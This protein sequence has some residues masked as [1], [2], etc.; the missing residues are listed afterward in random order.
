MIDE[1]ASNQLKENKVGYNKQS[2]N[3][4]RGRRAINLEN[5]EDITIKEDYYDFSTNTIKTDKKIISIKLDNKL[6]D[7]NKENLE[8]ISKPED[9]LEHGRQMKL[10]FMSLMEKVMEN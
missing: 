5:G 3:Y 7:S 4:Y 10:Q 2:N 9:L 6:Y 8:N 1:S